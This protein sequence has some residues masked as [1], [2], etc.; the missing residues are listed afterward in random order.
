MKYLSQYP[1][2]IIQRV[3]EL[4]SNQTLNIYLQAK[5]Q[6][7]HEI[8]NDKLLSGITQLFIL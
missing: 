7:N 5:Y 8:K 2:Y 3:K 1:D 6:N 4:I